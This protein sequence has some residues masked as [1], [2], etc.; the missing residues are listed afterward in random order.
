MPPG[1]YGELAISAE[2]FAEVCNT[3]GTYGELSAEIFTFFSSKW[4]EVI[5]R[6][7]VVIMFEDYK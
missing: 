2:F 5:P 3:P 6:T 7:G 1:T 4:K